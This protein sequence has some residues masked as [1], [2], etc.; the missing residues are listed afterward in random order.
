MYELVPLY[1]FWSPVHECHFYTVSETEKA[2]L[3][4][5]YPHVWTYECIACYVHGKAAE[6]QP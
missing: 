1:R 5:Q 4:E 2:K 3:V 6:V